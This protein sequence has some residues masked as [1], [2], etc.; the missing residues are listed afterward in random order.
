MRLSW[1]EIRARAGRFADEWKN[2]HYERGES[3]TFYNEF[4]EVFGIT[5]RRV[6]TFEEPVKKLGDQRGFIDLFWKGVLIVEQKSAGRDLIRAK[7]QVFEYFPGLKQHELPRY[8][9]ASDFQIFELYDLDDNT[10]SRF[11]LHQLP[12]HIEEFGFILGV[13]KRSFRDQDPVNI[14]AS[15][16]M[17]N[18]HDALKESGYV[19]HDLERFLVR[20]VFCLFADDT[21]I[22]EPRDIFFT[23]ITQ[24]TSPDGS[25]TGLWLS[26][27]FDVLNKPV[28]QRQ[29]NLDQDLAQFPYVNGDL[30]QERLALPS[31]NAA[32]R[33]HL[34]DAL[35]FSWDAISP[36]IFGALFQSVMNREE[37]RAQGAHY[38]TEKNI[39]KVIEPLFLDDLR[40][41]FERLSVRRDGGRR[42]ALEAFH[43]KLSTLRFF[44]PACGCGNFL[45]ISYRELRLLEL[46]LLKALRKDTQ[47]TLDVAHL[48]QIDV[49][50]FYGIEIG[51]FPARIAEIALWMMDHIMNNML[52]LEFGES[53]VRIPLK[54]SPHILPAD[55]LEMD[56]ANL[57]APDRCSYVLG[58][59]PFG[60]A[61]YQSPKQ[62]EQVRRI[63][64]LGGSGGTLDYVT[65]WFITAATYLQRSP[66]H[67][68]F[69]ATNSITQG[70]QVAQLWPV[71]FDR[72]GLEISFAHRTFA[73]GSDARG[74]AHVH[75]V[76]IGLTRSDQEPPLKRLFSYSDIHGDPSESDHQ[77][78]TP[79]LF[80]AGAVVNRHLVVE[81][82]GRPLCAVPQLVIG[83]KP[84]DDG[85][86][87]FDYEQR[88][89]FL[90]REPK[91]AKFLHPFIGSKEFINGIDRWILSLDGASPGDLRAMPVVMDRI[92]AVKSFRRR[93]ISA[94]TR[95]LANT[96]T[97]YHV[98]VIPD[99]AFLVIP[100]SS[101]ERR[102]YVPIAWLRPPT[103]PSNLVRVLLDADL[104]HFGILTSSMHMAWLRQIGGR[105]KSDYRYSVGIVYNTFPWPQ[106]TDNQRA[107]IRSFAQVVLD[108]RTQFPNSTLADLY[109]V[110]AMPPALRKAHRD[111]DAAV[112]KFYRSG[113]F[114]GDRDRAEHLFGLYEKLVMPPIT[115]PL[116]K[117]TRQRGRKEAQV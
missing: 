111:L 76:I 3:Q 53:Y 21:G 70:E 110:D 40:A 19:G 25:D 82:I 115:L 61:K 107:K 13:Q 87:I 2:A 33:S 9:L 104:W 39:L 73:W 8:V 37:R 44:D 45:I 34:N 20:L 80:D 114:S 71:L 116:Q 92:A 62:R 48:C 105:L 91:A 42:K 84:I 112:D 27:L 5:R 86:Y 54:K 28:E 4:F 93:S 102:E 26:Q 15:E 78:I 58:N 95:K 36:A 29:K 50:Q 74:M 69:V 31:F 38:T 23:L 106:A 47:L 101:S 99:R 60:G 75:V 24:R 79:Y 85:N 32:M 90:H 52:S 56:W 7:Q 17:A 22:F 63:A 113:Q 14:E 72:Y 57:I 96:P 49:D 18:L 51:E 89:E 98:T 64:Q 11:T 16:I 68:G 97:R 46:D 117:G 94:Q 6:A 43:Q 30:F 77:A 100:E 83:S 66:A 81:E 108:A 67:I 41:E 10:T 88:V 55:A 109:D 59:P 1:N 12:K 35:D 103:I 65:A